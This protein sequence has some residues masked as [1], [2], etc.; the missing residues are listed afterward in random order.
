VVGKIIITEITEVDLMLFLLVVVTEMGSMNISEME[1]FFGHPPLDLKTKQFTGTSLQVHNKTNI[2][3]AFLG[4][5]RLPIKPLLIRFGVSGIRSI[6]KN[7][8]D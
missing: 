5:L 7:Q 8:N 1:R 4:I 6:Q 2:A 3:V